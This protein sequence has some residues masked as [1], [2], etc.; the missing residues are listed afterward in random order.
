MFL[1]SSS[2]G[3]RS[4]SNSEIFFK[5]FL[6]YLKISENSTYERK[7]CRYERKIRGCPMLIV[8]NVSFINFCKILDLYYLCDNYPTSLTDVSPMFLIL[9]LQGIS[10]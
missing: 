3:T 5:E 8:E 2:A 7:S 4:S 6:I 10:L 9:G 1:Y